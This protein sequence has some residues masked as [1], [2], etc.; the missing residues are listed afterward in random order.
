MSASQRSTPS[1]MA[2][3]AGASKEVPVKACAPA[4]RRA[5]MGPASSA[6]LGM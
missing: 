1:S 5:A 2:T 4:A 6:P 3:M